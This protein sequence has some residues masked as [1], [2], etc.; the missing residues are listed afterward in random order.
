MIDDQ[1]LQSAASQLRGLLPVALF[2][3]FKTGERVGPEGAGGR[4]SPGRPRTIIAFPSGDAALSFAQRN[5]IR[6]TPRLQRLDLL[7]VLAALL[8]Q[9]P[10]AAV[11]FVTESADAVGPG[12]LPPGLR[13][14]RVAL[15]AALAQG[16][17]IELR[18]TP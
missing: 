13:L 4:A 7:Q 18:A 15:A 17:P 12:R 6:P 11:I 9:P 1:A 2:Y 16:E 14:D 3:V 5:S 8:R 10:G